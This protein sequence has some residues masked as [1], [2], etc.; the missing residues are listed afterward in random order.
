MSS[1]Q[2]PELPTIPDV[3]MIEGLIDGPMAWRSETAQQSD[4][5]V[6]VPQQ[7]LDELERIRQ[8]LSLERMPMLALHP[9]DYELEAC[10]KL[11][12]EARRRLNEGFGVIVL[13]RFPVEDYGQQEARQ[14]FWLLGTMLGRCVS[15]SIHGEMMVSVRDTGIPK[16][17]GVRGFRTNYPQRPHVDNSFNFS[18]PDLVSLLSLRKAVEGG[19]SKFISFFTVHNEMRQRYPELLPRLYQPFYQD[20]QIGRAHV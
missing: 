18:P 20:R 2:A 3:R 9:E 19:I 1:L 11:M 6:P 5:M 7:C 14:I 17:V 16:T 10:S 13:D 12:S 15:Q 8:K 4:W